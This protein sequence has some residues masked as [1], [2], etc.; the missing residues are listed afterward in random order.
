LVK[1]LSESHPLF[2]LASGPDDVHL[3]VDGR[4]H[5]LEDDDVVEVVGLAAVVE[6]W[7]L[8]ASVVEVERVVP[9]PH[10]RH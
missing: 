7:A 6:L 5:E 3:Y 8:D 4:V 10:A 1:S 2:G 9:P